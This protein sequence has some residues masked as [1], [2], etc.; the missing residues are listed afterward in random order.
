MSHAQYWKNRPLRPRRAAAPQGSTCLF[1]SCMS[2]STIP[3][4]AWRQ[5]RTFMYSMVM[6][7]DFSSG[8]AIK[9][10]V[11]SDRAVGWITPCLLALQ[12]LPID[13]F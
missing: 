12:Q 9:D 3:T 10:R 6:L 2:A 7:E 5:V 1:P 13:E 8:A 11:G 4:I